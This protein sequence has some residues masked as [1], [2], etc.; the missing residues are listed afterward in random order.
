[1]KVLLAGAHGQLGTALR[2]AAPRAV[3][4]VALGRPELDIAEEKSVRETL[5]RHAPDLVI[6]AAAY[7]R[8][9][10]AESA[11]PLAFRVNATGPRLL[12][13]A[14]A[15]LGSRLIHV[16]TDFVFAGERPVPYAATDVAEPGTAYGRSKLAGEQAV[17]AALGSQAVVVR[18]SWLYAAEGDNFL[19][20]M[21]KLMETRDSL[22]VVCDQVGTPTWADSLA[23]ALWEMAARP[24]IDGIQHWSDEGVASWYDFAVAIQEEAL[25]RQLLGRP[26]PVHAI[27]TAD[28]PTAARR[29]RY[30][31]L[32]K[33]ATTQALGRSPPHWRVN[34]RAMLDSL[35]HA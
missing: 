32:D 31:V 2:R 5:A 17:L 34:L 8:V 23:G 30:S 33:R 16:S 21:L 6:N 19:R 3:T 26:I 12:A 27:R 15:T 22:G 10:D 18:T 20:T 29:P 35:R 13:E 1:M 11:E 25:E 7:T 14:A 9:D 28:Y 4:L 24:D